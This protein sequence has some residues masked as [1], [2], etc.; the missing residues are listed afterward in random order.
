VERD[1]RS[2]AGSW[3]LGAGVGVERRKRAFLAASLVKR[4]TA[5]EPTHTANPTPT[6]FGA[7]LE[8]WVTMAEA[9]DGYE[10][11][12]QPCP[13][14]TGGGTTTGGAEPLGNLATRRRLASL[15]VDRRTVSRGPGGTR[16]PTVL[17][18]TDRPAPTLAQAEKWT[19]HRPATTVC[20][21]P[22]LGEPGHRDREGGEPQFSSDA[23]RL[24]EREGA[25]LQGF[26]A[27]Y[28]W[29]GNKGQ[30]WQQIGNAVPPALAAAV[31]S[32]CTPVHEP[33]AGRSE[34]QP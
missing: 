32:C 13:T 1:G 21:D 27:D 19:L 5:P 7:E 23:I 14:L 2:L 6:L 29:Q 31:A 22:R 24:T 25:I 18:P 17:V 3:L 30:R 16:V 20:A 9:V 28:P 33:P 11:I 26:P 10:G 34:D 4:V 8:R 12:D 15:V